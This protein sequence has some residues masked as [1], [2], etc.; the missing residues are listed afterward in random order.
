MSLAHSG[1]LFLDELPEFSRRVLESLRQPL[2]E[3]VVH[4]A[5]ANRSMTFPARV[6][7]IGAM[8]P[9]PCGYLGDVRRACQCPASAVE[10]YRR[11]LSGPLRDRFDLTVDLQA[12]PWHQMRDEAMS[13]SSAAVKA[14][15]V[16]ARA[17]QYAR[18][19]VINGQL[20][21]RALR[22]AC[23]L[24]DRA[25]EAMLGKAV[26]RLN[27]SVRAVARVLKVARTVA[28]LEDNPAIEA[29]HVAEALQLRMSE[30]TIQ[31]G[32]QN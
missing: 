19:G 11:R 24:S 4:I 25:S 20:E 3:G 10:R 21:N 12:V 15:V 29:R 30:G 13:E 5:R 6:T 32:H 17:R 16:A 2:E 7:L 14:R 22:S 1:V 31:G 18:Q 28:D 27:L 9:C 8:N 23:R 26:T